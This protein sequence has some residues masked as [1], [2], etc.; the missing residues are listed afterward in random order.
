MRMVLDRTWR[1]AWWASAIARLSRWAVQQVSRSSVTRSHHGASAIVNCAAGWWFRL[2]GGPSAK[3]LSQAAKQ[4]GTEKVESAGGKAAQMPDVVCAWAV[5]ASPSPTLLL[6][7]RHES[8]WRRRLT[9]KPPPAN[10]NWNFENKTTGSRSTNP[11][12]RYTRQF[13]P[14]PRFSF[15]A[16]STANL[17][18]A[19]SHIAP[20][21]PPSRLTLQ[22]L[23][24]TPRQRGNGGSTV[25]SGHGS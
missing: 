24:P 4:V 10:C 6:Q 11:N 5:C 7:G 14:P 20:R 17:S 8:A 25:R 2:A 23:S 19:V 3:P 9:R 22:S 15:T 16:S 18:L 13:D 21:S 1:A 12:N